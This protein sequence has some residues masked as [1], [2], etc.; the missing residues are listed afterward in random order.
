MVWSAALALVLGIGVEVAGCATNDASERPGSAAPLAAPGAAEDSPE[1][2]A[3]IVAA[4]ERFVGALGETRGA[5]ARHP[6][7]VEP[8][9][10][11][12]FRLTDHDSGM[13]VQVGLGGRTD[14]PAET[15]EGYVVYRG[16][17]G[18]GGDVVHHVSTEGVE[19]FVLLPRRLPEAEVVYRV[20]L[21]QGVAGLRLIDDTLELLDRDGA[22]RLRAAPP[23]VIDAGG[24]RHPARISVDGCAVDTNPAAPWGRSVT[25]PGAEECAVRV[26]WDDGTLAYPLLVDPAW[27]AT[28]S[29]AAVRYSH[30]ATLLASGKVLVAGGFGAGVL[31]ASELYDP[32]T[33]TW[34]ATGAMSSPRVRH[35]ACVLASGK[36]LAAGGFKGAA[37]ASAETYDPS[38]GLWTLTGSMTYGRQDHTGTTLASGKILVAG[39][40]G[41]S[42]NSSAELYDPAAGT[43]AV[44]GSLNVGRQD[45]TASLLANGTVLVTGGSGGTNTAEIYNAA[46]GTWALTGSMATARDL[47]TASTL[48]SG[49][50]LVAGGDA[51]LPA[52]AELFDPA[53]GTFSLTGSPSIVHTSG[54]AGVLVDAKVLLTGGSN[55]AL[56]VSELYDPAAATWANAGTLVTGRSSH[57]ATPL[58]DGTLIVAG[59]LAGG[60]FL[61]SAERF[62]QLANGVA[63]VGPGECLSGACADGV[64][65][66][67]TCAATCLACTAAKKGTGADGVCGAVA[68]GSDPNASCTDDGSPSCQHDGACDGA[69]ACQKYS[70]A[71]GCSPSP[72]ATGADCTSGFCVDGIC[73]DSACGGL[74]QAC[75]AAK[76][77]SGVDGVCGTIAAGTD[78]DAECTDQGVNSCGTN[79]ACNGAGACALYASGLACGVMCSAGVVTALGCDGAGTCSKPGAMTP[80]SPYACGSATACATTCAN[81]TACAPTAYCRLTDHT[82][83]PD[84]S[85]GAACTSPSQCQSGHCAAADGVCCDSDCSTA[86]SSCTAAKKGTGVDGVCGPTQ[87][88]TDPD[89]VCTADLGYPNSCKADGNCDGMGACRLLAKPGVVCGTPT[90]SAGVE[91]DLACS[92]AGECVPAQKPC[93][94]FAC[95]NGSTCASACTD[96]TECAQGE[97]CQAGVCVSQKA[98]GVACGAATECAMGVCQDGVCCN[99]ACTGQ[100]QACDVA[101]NPGTCTNV[102]GAPHGSTRPTC[103]AD[104]ECG[105]T[106]DGNNPTACV[107]M[108]STK[109]CGQPT[110]QSGVA[111]SSAC[112]GMGTCLPQPATPCKAF[113]CGPTSC[114]ESCAADTDCAQAYVC[115]SGECVQV[116]TSVC[117]GASLK[118]PDGSMHAC[119]P[120]ACEG[121]QC[122]TTCA[123]NTDCSGG[124]VCSP[125]LLCV[126]PPKST[127]EPSAPA[128]C[129]CRTPAEGP[130][131]PAAWWLLSAIVVALGRRRDPKKGAATRAIPAIAVAG[132][133]GFGAVAQGCTPSRDPSVGNGGGAE[134]H[135]APVASAVSA[136]SAAAANKLGA[137]RA[138]FRFTSEGDGQS[139]LG[140]A[141]IDGFE[142]IAGSRLR[143]VPKGR[144]SA[145]RARVDLPARAGEPARVEDIASGVAIELSLVGARPVG[146]GLDGGMALYE[147]ATLEGADLIHRAS[148]EGTED[149]LVHWDR[150][151][152]ERAEYDVDVRGVAGLRLVSSVLEFLDASGAPRVRM[153]AP[154]VIDAGGR[155]FD[156]TVEVAGCSY[157]A[158]PA[159][160]WGRPVT[161]PQAPTCRVTIAWQG[162]GVAYPALID[163][164]WTTTGSMASA[165]SNHAAV[166]LATGKAL[167][168]GGTGA[169]Q[170]AELYDRASGTWAAAANT[171]MGRQYHTATT[172]GSGKVL[173]AG[174]NISPSTAEI[175][176]PSAGTWTALPNM[177]EPRF[178][179]TASLLPSGKV[180]LANGDPGLGSSELF[181]PAA[182]SFAL[183][184]TMVDAL[185]SNFVAT[186]LANGKVLVTGGCCPAIVTAEVYDPVAGTW[187]ATGSMANGRSYHAGVL[188]GSGKV[189]VA[190]GWNGSNDIAEAELYDPTTGTWTST[191]PMTHTRETHTASLLSNG[192]ALVA[193]GSSSDGL[194]TTSEV[195]D[196]VAQTWA[197]AST[198]SDR[199]LHTATTLQTGEILV[200]GGGSSA[201]ALASALLFALVPQ[202]GTC[203]AAEECAAGSCVDGVCCNQACTGLCQAC[204]AAKKGVGPD[205]TCAPILKGLDPDAECA[206][207]GAAS[208]GTNGACNGSGACDLYAA[209][210]V[211][212]S[213]CA[214]G[215][216]TASTCSGAGACGSPS[217]TSCAPYG[218]SNTVCLTT[219]TADTD[220]VTSAW[221]DV[222]SHA[223]KPKQGSGVACATASQC[224]S[225]FCADGFCCN[226][227]CS[228]VCQA[229][230]AAKNGGADG[231]CGNVPAGSDPDAECADGW[232][233]CTQTGAC[234]GLGAC[235][236]YSMPTGCSPGACATGADCA[237]GVCAD[238]VC[239]DRACGTCEACTAAK[240][241]SGLDG[242]CGA[243]AAGT[244]PNHQCLDSFPACTQT[245]AC[246]GLGACATEVAPC[247][248]GPCSSG[249]DCASGFCVDGVCCESACAG[250][251]QVCAAALGSSKNGSCEVVA[252]GLDPRNQCSADPVNPCGADGTCDGAGVCRSYAPSGASCKPSVCAGG[253][254]TSSTCNGGGACVPTTTPCDPFVC[255]DGSS[256]GTSC[257]TGADCAADAY[258]NG[259]CLP[260]KKGGDAC[261]AGA[262]CTSTYCADGVC[263]DQACG[264]QCEACDE[265][266]SVGMCVPVSGAP[267]APRAACNATAAACA[268]QCDGVG[269]TCSY[270]D[271]TT[272]C[273]QP[274]C[275]GGSETVSACDGNGGCLG[276]ESPCGSYACGPT[277]CKI[278]CAV[279]AD[280]APGFSCEGV[281]CIMVMGKS[282]D[283]QHSLVEGGKV[284]QDCSPY[285]CSGSTCPSACVSSADCVATFACDAEKKCVPPPMAAAPGQAGG[286]SYQAAGTTPWPA[287]VWIVAALGLIA[288]ARRRSVGFR[289]LDFAA[290]SGEGPNA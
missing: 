193:F 223:C 215:V 219:C 110:C 21:G 168:V 179:H 208:C 190:G 40:N 59:G 242:I 164:A 212:A 48:A 254:L 185:R 65:C 37:L 4:R 22:P 239:C 39:G 38:T 142:P 141:L 246:D 231:V 287:S 226:T 187:S 269:T 243:V 56:A 78:P 87:A 32:T 12:G 194:P 288:R 28:G 189:L 192:K 273:G 102:T 106:C 270:P 200:A 84:L 93:S 17:H 62:A 91:T 5:T 153:A 43:W 77:G 124:A 117:V 52:T 49:K 121:T 86:C 286:C 178:Q 44:T 279:D 152:S 261:A 19:D 163:P 119:A 162:L 156:P 207:Q 18:S 230:S 33:G 227:S 114:K 130:R 118:A 10:T 66:S 159:A 60:T 75:T 99:E 145:H 122:K 290:G 104:P 169:T 277:G 100:C 20:A 126:Q 232:P 92:A 165:R 211:C 125:D 90:C 42:A 55:G 68:A 31:A 50:V 135:D 88:D 182:S 72:C 262:E 94:P 181:D 147:A 170:S 116:T 264:G 46:A 81:D 274:S 249:A 96:S 166:L 51:T 97:Y 167:V 139:V 222:A 186:S 35:A 255:A 25:A 196:P 248:S 238:G 113:A 108:P 6:A 244:D 209:G 82:C 221:C 252:A 216:I 229:C 26:T 74:C 138:R 280:C 123:S 282:C 53:S 271:K 214:N 36:V 133:L 245:G 171:L 144:A 267:R 258:C 203:T 45:H 173:V 149:Y 260:R 89:N 115:S 61:A 241:G 24:A 64:C 69:G 151:S 98:L 83:Q 7:A 15:A 85:N 234:D 250:P 284:V 272:P 143:A 76:K 105:G 175:Y 111:Q 256:C 195:F 54:A 41:V 71:S 161:A 1:A 174:G 11:A 228:G 263:C 213:T 27:T 9:R 155:R 47:H 176:D 128:G 109:A 34:A 140:P 285:L 220:C 30:T 188:L 266:T 289:P 132:L 235:A 79:G 57:T 275:A 201:G 205:G 204:S 29:M 202:G 103:S 217:M 158:S 146:I 70:M 180:L 3:V 177:K 210:T 276:G 58:P 137:V 154:Y 253:A 107:N 278:S 236:T 247:S 240:K 67:T 129:G 184:G 224:Q 206:N 198:T 225:G 8:D 13:S 63:C 150:P 112:D 218:C 73:C 259:V 136:V 2:R 257:T 197:A 14:A 16:G 283:G 183:S 80:C 157:D 134:A 191:A 237:S 281:A 199:Y 265:P 160:P 251:C 127:S 131:A 148:G 101:S 172:L 233:A 23:Y 120:Y 268:G 95:A